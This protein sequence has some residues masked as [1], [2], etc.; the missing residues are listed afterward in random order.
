MTKKTKDSTQ[1]PQIFLQIIGAIARTERERF[2]EIQKDI[3]P[4]M[5]LGEA[6]HSCYVGVSEER[7]VKVHCMRPTSGAWS[8]SLSFPVD[9]DLKFGL[10]LNSVEWDLLANCGFE[11][12]ESLAQECLIQ[13]KKWP[14]MKFLLMFSIVAKT[15]EESAN[16]VEQ[17]ER[18]SKYFEEN[19]I[20]SIK[21]E[22]DNTSPDEFRKVMQELFEEVQ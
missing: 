17:A 10:I 4:D 13:N 1:Y 16:A 12:I 20:D 8:I 7:N 5:L 3:D 22:I 14:L 6:Y 19:E 11:K 2:I 18:L 15:D 9:E 21:K